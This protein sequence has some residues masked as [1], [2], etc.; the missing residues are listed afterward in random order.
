MAHAYRT[1]SPP[2]AVTM[3]NFRKFYLLDPYTYQRMMLNKLN[4]TSHEP[5][6]IQIKKLVQDVGK[7]RIEDKNIKDQS[8]KNFGER[9]Q[10]LV[11]APTTQ[12]AQTP[13]NN[14]QVASSPPSTAATAIIDALEQKVAKTLQSKAIKLYLALKDLPGVVISTDNIKV[15]GDT[16][17][18]ST[19]SIINNLAKKNVDL[20]YPTQR[21]LDKIIL[22]PSSNKIKSLIGNK[23]ASLYI[24]PPPAPAPAPVEE[25]LLGAVGGLPL[26]SQLSQSL[27]L[28]TPKSAKRKK[29]TLPSPIQASTP[30]FIKKSK[31]KGKSKANKTMTDDD[32]SFLTGRSRTQFFSDLEKSGSGKKKAWL[33]LFAKHGGRKRKHK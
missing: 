2:P 20:K 16:L 4:D 30:G 29:N 19:T 31:S 33:T 21:L 23:E 11:G 22:S 3:N 32:Q 6:D 14:P 24:T 15:D 17:V 1:P 5:A 28:G 26:P 8:W 18:G 7:T 25:E 9:I 10:G 27:D 13:S 12:P